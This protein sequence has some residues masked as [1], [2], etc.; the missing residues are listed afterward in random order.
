MATKPYRTRLVRAEVF[1]F[2]GESA[3]R[4]GEEQVVRNQLV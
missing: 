1:P 3:G 4:P 2:G